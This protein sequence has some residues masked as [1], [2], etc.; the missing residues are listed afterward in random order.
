MC[1]IIHDSLWRL[2]PGVLELEASLGGAE[3]ILF[4]SFKIV[5]Y[6]A[7]SNGLEYVIKSGL[8]LSLEVTKWAAL[9]GQQA[10]GSSCLSASPTLPYPSACFF[11]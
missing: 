7:L 10:P 2:V 1:L 3:I 9:T 6:T 4:F 5:K 11:M 8:S